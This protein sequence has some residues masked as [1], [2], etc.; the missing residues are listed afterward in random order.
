M[1][2]KVHTQAFSGPFDL[3][4]TLVSRQK[5]A[6]GSISITEVADQYLE[7]VRRMGEMDL[8]VASDFVLVAST[9][10]DMKAASLV[11]SEPVR[12]P[13][14][15][16]EEDEL[17]NLSQDEAREVLV[18]RLVTYK[19]FRNA[20]AALG[21]RLEAESLMLPRTAGPD[22]EFMG[23]MPDY[24]EGISLRSLGVICADL[25]ARR[26]SFLLDAE[27]VAPRRLPIV[28][29]VAAVDRITRA[30]GVVTFTELLQGDMSVETVVATFLAMLELAKRGAITVSQS[31]VFGEIDVARVEGAPAFELDEEALTSIG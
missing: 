27:H 17:A 15:D 8:E 16:L 6:I 1:S 20:G 19:Q 3:L 22:P 29:T 14:D 31:Q 28:L 10:L 24:L 11:P 13:L 30:K 23:L 18:D 21:S 5:L 2:Y 12:R 7:E 25:T 4:L 26:E 9:L